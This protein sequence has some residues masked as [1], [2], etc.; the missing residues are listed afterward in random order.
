M[1][2]FGC[3]RLCGVG[4][5]SVSSESLS[6]KVEVIGDCVQVE[7]TVKGGLSCKNYFAA[8]KSSCIVIL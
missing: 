5:Y 4:K 6:L 2:S 3:I 7:I 1:D 8:I